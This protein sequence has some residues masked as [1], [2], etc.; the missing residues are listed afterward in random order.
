VNI[1]LHD[2]ER[3]HRKSKP[4]PNL[5][6]MKISAFHKAHGDCVEWWQSNKNYDWVYSSKVFDFTPDNPNLPAKTIRGGTGYNAKANEKYMILS[7]LPEK[8][9][10]MFPDYS[11]YPDYDF[12]L[13]YL[14]RGC[15]RNCPFCVVTQKEGNISRQVAKLTDFWAHQAYIKLLDPN[16]LACVDREQI[17]KS[18][19]D[20][21]AWIDFTQ[22][23]DVRLINKTIISLLN[24]VKIKTLYTAWDNP[25]EDLTKKFIFVKEHFKIKDYRR[26]KVYVLTNFNSSHIEDLERVRILRDLGF[27]PYVMIY[28]KET[29]PQITINLQRYVNNKIIFRSCID[30][31]AYKG[32]S[33]AG[34]YLLEG[35][36]KP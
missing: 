26:L 6:I 19:A 7:A 28:N 32:D 18:L 20:S 22:G 29:A 34:R 21:T 12:A 10:Q 15:P 1:G 13:G 27:D 4:F 24:Q 23:L 11:L 36:M 30:F 31:T 5:A 2:A 35:S 33:K 9:N 25:K 16:I 8:Y 17:I 3:E 14:T